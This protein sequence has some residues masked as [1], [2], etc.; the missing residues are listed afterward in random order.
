M[1]LYGTT[2]FRSLLLRF[3]GPCWSL[4][5]GPFKVKD[6]TETKESNLLACY[7]LTQSVY[8]IACN[9]ASVL[10]LFVVKINLLLSWRGTLECSSVL[11]KIVRHIIRYAASLIPLQIYG[12]HLVYFSTAISHLAVR[13]CYER[14]YWTSLHPLTGTEHPAK[15]G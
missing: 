12:T 13:G 8:T 14:V 11:S 10:Q 5:L 9:S 15:G 3:W 4:P 2:R 7:S 6:K 1:S